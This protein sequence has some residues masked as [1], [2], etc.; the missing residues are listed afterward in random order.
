MSYVLSRDG[1]SA[2]I[3]DPQVADP[4]ISALEEMV[5]D[6]APAGAGNVLASM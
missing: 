1:S 4:R 2:P 5:C 6:V 3:D